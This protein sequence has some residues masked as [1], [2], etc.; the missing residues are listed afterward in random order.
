MG[1]FRDSVV[2]LLVTLSIPF[3]LMA[4]DVVTGLSK[5]VNQ[6]WRY[7]IPTYTGLADTFQMVSM[8][9]AF[10]GPIFIP[11][12]ATSW[13]IGVWFMFWIFVPGLLV[14]YLIEVYGD[15][16]DREKVF[17]FARLRANHEGE[18]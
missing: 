17:E 4:V 14:P 1:E 16:Q 10:A 15:K 13:E 5:M 11:E 7:F 12:I 6:G 2:A 8:V 3:M 18:T 9:A